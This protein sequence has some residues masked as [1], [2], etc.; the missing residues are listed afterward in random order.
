MSGWKKQTNILASDFIKKIEDMNISRIIYTDINK[1]G[2]KQGPNL[3]ET[4]NFSNLTK[5]PVLISGGISSIHDVKKLKNIKFT[6]IK[7]IK[8]AYP[9]TGADLKGLM[10]SA[11][12]DPN[13]V[14]MFEHKHVRSRIHDAL[15]LT[16]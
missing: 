6:N 3:T 14:V 10:K 7:G 9:S 12:Y 16:K 11:Y 5:I 2:T 15:N 4:Q 13:P 8:I 1:D